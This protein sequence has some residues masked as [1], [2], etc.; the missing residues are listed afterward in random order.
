MSN[1]ERFFVNRECKYFPCHQVEK[2]EEFN[3][4]F[5]YCP[6]YAL[7][8]ACG[9]DMNW[10]ESGGTFIKDC[11]GCTVPHRKDSADYID[12]RFAELSALAA[13]NHDE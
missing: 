5:C 9:G 10:I 6:L 11:S 2:E 13:S 4:K 8:D 7:G 12:S 1:N 3:C